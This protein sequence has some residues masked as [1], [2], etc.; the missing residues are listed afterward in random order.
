LA[1]SLETFSNH[2][3]AQAILKANQR[4]LLPVK[5]LKE[6]AGKGLSGEI[7]GLWVLAG[8]AKLLRE[9]QVDL[10]E[11]AEQ[12]GSVVRVAIDDRQVATIRL[13]DQLRLDSRETIE[14]LKHKKLA[15]YLLSGDSK[16]ITAALA[17]ELGVEYFAEVLP[18]DKAAIIS[19]LQASGNQ[20]AFVGDGINDAIALTSADLGIAIGSGSDVALKSGDVILV[21]SK[22]ADVESVL[23]IGKKTM[24]NIKENLFWAFL[25][26]SLGIPLAM[27]VFITGGYYIDPMF[28]ALAMSLSSVCVVLNA[29][30]LRKL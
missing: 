27:G 23:V 20:V 25:Y 22:L 26:N 19:E 14:R 4:E 12:D 29:L 6:Y 13:A 3:F 17:E 16:K 28:G 24:I 9:H 21:D 8:N 11:A 5:G 18:A 30:R 15:L 7:N 10:P 1:A 2:P